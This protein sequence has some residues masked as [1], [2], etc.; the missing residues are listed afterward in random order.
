MTRFY[1]GKLRDH[2]GQ[3]RES[4][5]YDLRKEGDASEALRD[6][7]AKE[8]E[9][10]DEIIRRNRERTIENMKKDGVYIEGM[11]RLVRGAEWPKLL[12][13]ESVHSNLIDFKGCYNQFFPSY[14][15]STF[16]Y[17]LR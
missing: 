6:Q 5:K 12:L 4:I 8:K 10:T 17:S 2:E 16:R 3:F 7:L 11:I 13:A 14:S 1:R 9:R 15:S